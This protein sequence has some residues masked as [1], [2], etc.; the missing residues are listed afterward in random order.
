MNGWIGRSF[1]IIVASVVCLFVPNQRRAGGVEWW[2]VVHSSTLARHARTVPI[3]VYPKPRGSIH[4]YP[5]HSTTTVG[6]GNFYL[7]LLAV[8]DGRKEQARQV[9]SSLHRWTSWPGTGLPGSREAGRERVQGG[10]LFAETC[11]CAVA[12][13]D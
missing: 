10:C 1:F 8:L 9:G 12:G 11:F 5:I 4:S 2:V 13:G 6:L 3:I 7:D